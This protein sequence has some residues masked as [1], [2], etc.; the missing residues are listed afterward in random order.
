MDE[1]P[2]RVKLMVAAGP[3]AQVFTFRDSEPSVHIGCALGITIHATLESPRFPCRALSME[4]FST[5][6]LFFCCLLHLGGDTH[7]TRL[8][9]YLLRLG[10]VISECFI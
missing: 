1:H 10:T 2:R 8:V 9:S 5:L 4:L 3:H 7:I 6:S